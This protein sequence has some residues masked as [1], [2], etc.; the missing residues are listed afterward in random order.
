MKT[1]KDNYGNL[2]Q[3]NETAPKTAVCPHC[4]G[5]LTLRKRRAMNNAHIAYFWRHASNQNQNCRARK[6]PV[7]L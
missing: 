1:A 4:G 5:I 2:I 6:R 7:L 3:A